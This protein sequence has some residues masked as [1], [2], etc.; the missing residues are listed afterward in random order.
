MVG[1]EGHV[2]YNVS[3]RGVVGWYAELRRGRHPRQR[4]VSGMTNTPMLDALTAEQR[5]GLAARHPIGRIA[6]PAEAARTEMRLTADDS[7][8]TTGAIFSVDGLTRCSH[9]RLHEAHNRFRVEIGNDI[10]HAALTR[11]R[12]QAVEITDVAAAGPRLCVGI[13]SLI[14][15]HFMKPS[16]QRPRIC[17]FFA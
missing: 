12:P 2:A 3:K 13:P 11:H 7:S 17:F 6:D 4:G 9:L 5:T 10:A 15:I 14:P 8:Y 1:H 16:T